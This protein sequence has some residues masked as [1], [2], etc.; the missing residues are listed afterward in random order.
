MAAPP[1]SGDGDDPYLPLP[2][3]VASE[4][5]LGLPGGGFD[6]D[7]PHVVPSVL[8]PRLLLTDEQHHRE[9]LFAAAIATE[10]IRLVAPAD[11]RMTARYAAE[12]VDNSRLLCAGSPRLHLSLLRGQLKWLRGLKPGELR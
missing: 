10:F 8:P 7:I 6:G 2:L 5:L 12:T 1:V 3:A 11:S 9:C 4:G